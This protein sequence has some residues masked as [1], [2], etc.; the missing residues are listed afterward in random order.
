MD[1]DGD[2]DDEQCDF[3]KD[4]FEQSMDSNDRKESQVSNRNY[5]GSGSGVKSDG[6]EIAMPSEED[7]E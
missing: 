3:N 1:G 4:K 5:Q 6:K 2:G 7:L